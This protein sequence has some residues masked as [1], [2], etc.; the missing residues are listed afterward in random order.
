[1]IWFKSAADIW[2]KNEKL[3]MY[4]ILT[5]ELGMFECIWKQYC[6]QYNIYVHFLF[7]CT[8][9]GFIADNSLYK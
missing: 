9:E 8:D 7:T 5:L 6:K 2:T 3:F 1:M 4:F